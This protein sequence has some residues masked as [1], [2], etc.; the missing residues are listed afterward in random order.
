MAWK[1][2][3]ISFS[4]HALRRT[5]VWVRLCVALTPFPFSH[6]ALYERVWFV[7]RY[8]LYLNPRNVHF[9]LR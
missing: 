3:A 7:Y 2:A 5:I 9:T 8:T 6:R 1:Q 4:R